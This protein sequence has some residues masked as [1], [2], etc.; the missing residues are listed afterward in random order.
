MSQRPGSGT[1]LGPFTA[2]ETTFL[3]GCVALALGALLSFGRTGSGLAVVL[4]AFAAPAALGA[5]YVWRRLRSRSHVEFASFSLDQLG[6]VT[7]VVGLILAVGA[8][9]GGLAQLLGILGSL[10]MGAAT[11]G[12]TWVASFRADFEVDPDV[13][14]LRRDVISTDD[15]AWQGA[16]GTAGSAGPAGS[17]GGPAA[18]SAPGTAAS[19][20]TQAGDAAASGSAGQGS[21]AH[22]TSAHGASAHGTS[23]QGAGTPSDAAPGSVAPVTS[24]WTA[25]AGARPGVHP[26]TPFWFAVPD[27]R[28]ALNRASGATEFVLTPGSWWLAVRELDGGRLVVRHDDGR[29]GMLSDTGQLEIG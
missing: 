16:A 18:G 1:V 6:A 12:A 9:Q 21:A 19:F 5:T 27:A 3:A 17:A 2:R 20:G 29:E 4:L 28:P 22:G 24:G 15:A 25:S 26:A 13:P 14:L 8:L 11:L 7:A 23:A 10:A